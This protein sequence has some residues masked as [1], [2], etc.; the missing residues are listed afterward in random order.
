MSDPRRPV[1]LALEHVG[2][3]GTARRDRIPAIIQYIIPFFT[4]RASEAVYRVAQQR[5]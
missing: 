2:H 4:D 3:A 1:R 5:T